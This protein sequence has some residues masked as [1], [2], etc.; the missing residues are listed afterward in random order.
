MAFFISYPLSALGHDISP[1]ADRDDI[2][3]SSIQRI[4]PLFV[5]NNEIHLFPP[6]LTSSKCS[7]K[8]SNLSTCVQRVLFNKTLISSWECQI[9]LYHLVKI[10]C[11]SL[12]NMSEDIRSDRPDQNFGVTLYYF[13]FEIWMNCWKIFFYDIRCTCMFYFLCPP[14][15]KTFIFFTGLNNEDKILLRQQAYKQSIHI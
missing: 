9:W 6:T 5:S 10:P 2:I 3:M 4:C 1:K 8:L 12:E 13:N 7:I 11:S 15:H 14:E